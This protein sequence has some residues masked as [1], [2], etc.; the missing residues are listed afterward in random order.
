MIEMYKDGLEYSRMERCMMQF[1]QEA[2]RYSLS[3][4][5]KVEISKYGNVE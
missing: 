4:Q 2:R 1:K 3:D 5:G